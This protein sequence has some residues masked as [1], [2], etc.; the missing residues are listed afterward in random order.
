M[1]QL[2]A[3]EFGIGESA[4]Y[5]HAAGKK[6][7]EE[8]MP[9]RFYA[10]HLGIAAVCLKYASPEK[11]VFVDA[12]L[13]TNSHQTLTAYLTIQEGLSSSP[14][15]ALDLLA[16]GLGPMDWPAIVIAN[17]QLVAEPQLV[18]FISQHADWVCV[19]SS[20][21]AGLNLGNPG[22]SAVGGASVFISRQRW[23]ASDISQ[24][25]PS[26]LIV[27]ARNRIPLQR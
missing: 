5:P 24:A 10:Q 1:R 11:R 19:H 14:Q 25:D 21:P 20:P 18:Q 7:L 27:V 3:F 6:L 16:E 15:S 12:R 9:N 23:S 22:N 17:D 26:W 4:W 13:E 2:P 8:G